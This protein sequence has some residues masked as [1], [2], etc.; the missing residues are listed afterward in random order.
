[1]HNVI[2]LF[3]TYV[4]VNKIAK[5]VEV[6][7]KKKRIKHTKLVNSIKG[8]IIIIKR[9]SKSTTWFTQ[10]KENSSKNCFETKIME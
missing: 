2:D 4:K 5:S 1:M 8:L 3:D 9:L 10:I 7:T 6:I